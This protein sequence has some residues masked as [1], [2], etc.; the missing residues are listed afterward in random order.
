[1]TFGWLNLGW[2]NLDTAQIISI[3]TCQQ[4]AELSTAK[5]ELSSAVVRYSMTRVRSWFIVD[6][7]LNMSCHVPHIPPT[8]VILF[9]SFLS[10]LVL[11]LQHRPCHPV[12]WTKDQFQ[13]RL[14]SL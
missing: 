3:G 5:L 11:L 9:S 4:L 2:L 10:T 12:Q 13:F 6:L 1:M 14:T 8:L 7:Q